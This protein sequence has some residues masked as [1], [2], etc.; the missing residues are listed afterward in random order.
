MRHFAVLLVLVVGCGSVQTPVETPERVLSDL[1]SFRE[2][3]DPPEDVPPDKR[4]VVAVEDCVVEGSSPPEKVP[5]GILMSEEM[6]T[7]AAQFKVAYEEVRGLYEVDLATIE[8]ERLIY[9]RYLN[10][11]DRDVARWREKARR[12]WWEENRGT[13]GLAVGIVVGA[14]L[15]VGMAAAIDAATD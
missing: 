12:T 4:L 8:R 5:P 1:I 3:P 7:R 13:F 2:I 9:E 6:A 14:G 10:A 11:A 15:A